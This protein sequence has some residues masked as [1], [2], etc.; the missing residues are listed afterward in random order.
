MTI[1]FAARARSTRYA[2]NGMGVKP[3]DDSWLTPGMMLLDKY[4]VESVLGKGGMG[5]VVR[6]YHPG[7]DERVAIKIL[8]DD[9]A[10]PEAARRFLRE[11]QATVRLKSEH[12]ARVSDVGTTDEGMSYMVMELLEGGDIAQMLETQR[13]DAPDAVTL[14]LQACVALAEAHALGIVHRDIKPANLFVILRDGRAHVKVLDFGISKVAAGMDGAALTQTQSMLGTPAY[15]S[16]EQMRSAR[17]VDLR[18]D[19]WSIGTVLYEMIEG[20]LPFSAENFSEMVVKVSIDAP[21]PPVVMEP[22][23]AAVVMRCLEKSADARYASTLELAQAL[24]PFARDAAAARTAVDAIARYAG[25]TVGPRRPVSAPAG[26]AAWSGPAADPSAAVWTADLVD[27]YSSRSTLQ[28]AAK[29]RWVL[30]GAVAAAVL[31]VGI[32]VIALAAGSRS[33]APVVEDGKMVVAPVV[34]TAPAVPSASERSA[35]AVVTPPAGTDAG[36]AVAADVA[37]PPAPGKGSAATKAAGS[38]RHPTTIPHP[39]KIPPA[40]SS[41][42]AFST[43]HAPPQVAPRPRR[44]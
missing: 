33:K 18:S 17:T 39:P 19:V 1:T 6:A 13:F 41:A 8:R 44:P 22:A 3:A 11:A 40:G 7:L 14:V 32:V 37:P 24:A 21:T 20:E 4:R 9:V 26:S 28:A 27:T 35:A 12:V 34:P 29:R 36:S 23:L 42:D 10:D 30:R 2:A 16:P 38:S 15:M 5:I 31:G 43:P 25:A